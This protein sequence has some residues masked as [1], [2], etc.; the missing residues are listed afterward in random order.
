MGREI[1][2]AFII[3]ASIG[4]FLFFRSKDQDFPA[5]DKVLFILGAILIAIGC[6]FV[7]ITHDVAVLIDCILLRTFEVSG[8]FIPIGYILV[9]MALLFFV[10]KLIPESCMKIEKNFIKVTKYA[11]FHEF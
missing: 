3:I 6:F 7:L 11:C 10:D 8:E 5:R 2:I 4:G 9:L 1:N